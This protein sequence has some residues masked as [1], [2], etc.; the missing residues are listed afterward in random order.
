MVDGNKVSVLVDAQSLETQ[1]K[2]AEDKENRNFESILDDTEK[3][4]KKQTDSEELVTTG[5]VTSMIS[6]SAWPP[7][8]E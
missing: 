1:N 6:L 4:N 7:N 8:A 5:I 3:E 2:K